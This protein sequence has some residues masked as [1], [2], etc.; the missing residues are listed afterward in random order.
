MK[1]DENRTVIIDAEHSIEIGGASWDENEL[2]IRRRKDL[3]G[4]F[5]VHSSSEIPVNGH[6]NISELFLECLKN[7]L[8][9]VSAM[10]MV[11]NEI[12]DSSKRQNSKITI[13]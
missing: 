10:T 9:N 4:R 1:V 11:F 5:D 13:I 6:V 8:I 7:D 3:N 2:A 12:I